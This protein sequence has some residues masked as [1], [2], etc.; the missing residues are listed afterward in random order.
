VLQ[1]VS[2]TPAEAGEPTHNA[3]AQVVFPSGA[4]VLPRLTVGMSDGTLY[5]HGQDADIPA[6]MTVEYRSNRPEVVSVD[7]DGT[8]RTRG[9]GVATVTAIVRH[10]GTERT[11]DFVIRV[12]EDH[13][14]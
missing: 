14:R 3:A 11:T 1:P 6:G 7:P 12:Q 8:I 2:A 10:N 5:G 13:R 9:A 4:V